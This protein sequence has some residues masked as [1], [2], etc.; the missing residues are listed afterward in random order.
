MDD[1]IPLFLYVTVRA[2]IENLGAEIDFL[3][4]FID[5]SIVSGE[6]RVLLTTLK[7]CYTQLLLD[8][9]ED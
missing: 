4:D 2:R 3:E 1:V 5:M 9:W 7:A 8:D 6:S